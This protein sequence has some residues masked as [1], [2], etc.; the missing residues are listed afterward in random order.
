ME[1]IAIN[2]EFDSTKQYFLFKMC[3]KK[4]FSGSSTTITIYLN[5]TINVTESVGK[6]NII[7]NYHDSLLGGHLGVEKTLKTI[8]QFYSW[9]NMSVEIGEYISK[10][11]ICEKSK[12][13]QN[14]KA[15]ME[16]SSLGSVLFDY[17]YIDFIGPILPESDE[18]R[19]YIFT[20]T[21]DLTK[22]LV[23]VPTTDYTAITTAK[24]LLENILLQQIM[25][26][27]QL[28]IFR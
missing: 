1:E 24:C 19:R 16:I 9:P 13:T 21:C 17:T 14:I 22:F 18:G 25:R 26:M 4:Q 15:P 2:V 10:C 12:V 8:S 27:N 20:A 3:M 11:D 5:R 23:A 7:K 28:T 6:E